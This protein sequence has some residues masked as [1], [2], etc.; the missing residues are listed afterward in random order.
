MLL[1]ITITIERYS[2]EPG[3]VPQ[4]ILKLFQLHHLHLAKYCCILLSY[5]VHIIENM[6]LTQEILLSKLFCLITLF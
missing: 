4:N 3:R 6:N 2:E 5:T 1:L